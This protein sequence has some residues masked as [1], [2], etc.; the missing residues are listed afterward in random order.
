MSFAAPELLLALLAVPAL[1]AAA[2]VVA[3][4][5]RRFALRLPAARALVAAAGPGRSP[6]ARRLPAALLLAG[7]AALAV[8]L[9]RPQATVR[10]PVEQASVLLVTDTS[11]SMLAEDVAP[12]RLAAAQRA[13]RDFLDEVPDAVKVGTVSFADTASLSQAPTTDHDAV[14]SAVGGLAAQGGTATGEA[15]DTALDA[16]RPGGT[17]AGPPAAVVL[18]SD[19]ATTVGRDPAQVAATARRLGVPV[20]T[21]ALGTP[22]GTVPDPRGGVLRV[23]PDPESLTRIAGASGGRAFSAADA[24][25]LRAVYREL[26]SRLG[27]EPQERE[28]TVAFTGAGLLLVAG[29]LAAGVRRRPTLT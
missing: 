7:V 25:G 17:A 3:R 18:L 9:A 28:I 16:L 11:G 14:R 1:L 27:T 15:L 10:V 6:W 13:A 4:R 21:V 24:D 26:G 22:G 19:G 23:P 8:A 2:A 12:S 5:R 29:G 20:H